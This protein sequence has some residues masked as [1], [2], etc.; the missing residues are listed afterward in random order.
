VRPYTNTA[1]ND[2]LS[3]LTQVLDKDDAQAGRG[4]ADVFALHRARRRALQY[5]AYDSA[6]YELC[7]S[8]VFHMHKTAVSASTAA[9]KSA[10]KLGTEHAIKARRKV[11]PWYYQSTAMQLVRVHRQ[12]QPYLR[13]PAR[14]ICV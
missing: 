13:T 3:A 14:T 8:K 7:D 10:A 12:Q 1:L 6:D 4:L 5:S 2:A 11:S 9:L